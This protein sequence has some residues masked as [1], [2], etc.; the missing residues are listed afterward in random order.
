M[1]NT[2]GNANM[3]GAL[4]CKCIAEVKVLGKLTGYN[5]VFYK[6]FP[7]TFTNGTISEEQ[8]CKPYVTD[9]FKEKFMNNGIKYIIIVLNTVIRMACIYII[10]KVGCSTESN[11]MIYTTNV[12]F[13]CT[14]F[15]TGILPMLCTANLEH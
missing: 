12:V 13:I 6:K 3:M 9:Y 11:E 15:N 1:L 14:F 10:Q 5:K 7:M 8:I 4:K 2:K